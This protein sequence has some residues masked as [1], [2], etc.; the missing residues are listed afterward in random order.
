[1]SDGTEFAEEI[2]DRLLT[3]V[4]SAMMAMLNYK[5]DY[6]GMQFNWKKVKSIYQG[7]S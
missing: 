4:T 1:M 6:S 3:N 7:Q 5:M 2:I